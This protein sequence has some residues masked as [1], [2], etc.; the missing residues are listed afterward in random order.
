MSPYRLMAYR[1]RE[2]PAPEA[3]A[4]LA[5]KDASRSVIP[6]AAI[7][8][9]FFCPAAKDCDKVVSPA[10][11]A[12]QSF[13]WTLWLVPTYLGAA[14]LIASILRARHRKR[15]PSGL[16]AGFTACAVI[17]SCVVAGIGMLFDK[18]SPTS[19]GELAALAIALLFLVKGL[20]RRG[21]AR[22]FHFSNVYLAGSLPIA[23]LNLL[24]GEYWGAWLFLVAYGLLAVLRGVTIAAMVRAKCESASL[25]RLAIQGPS[26]RV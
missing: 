13:P 7:V 9:A 14:L 11:L 18:A 24:A 19:I 10:D 23:V 22:F 1:E 16:L 4:V 20:R 5:R 3:R 17:A 8:I 21:W 25:A 15:A 6:L 12:F 26:L 2:L